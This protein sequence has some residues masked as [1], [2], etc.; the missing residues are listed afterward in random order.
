MKLKYELL[1]LKFCAYLLT[2]RDKQR[3]AAG[4]RGGD[5]KEFTTFGTFV[6]LCIRDIGT[7]HD[8]FRWKAVMID[9]QEPQE[10]HFRKS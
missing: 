4:M 7:R 9:D 1:I 8:K 5:S 6:E 2:S 10:K 3:R